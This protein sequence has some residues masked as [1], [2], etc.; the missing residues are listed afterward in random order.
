[1][2]WLENLKVGDSVIVKTCHTLGRVAT[3][4]K[5]R[6]LHIVVGKSKFRKCGGDMVGAY[7]HG[8]PY[9]AEA[10]QE[11]ICE[12]KGRRAAYQL[13]NYSLQ[14]FMKVPLADL[15]SFI[16]KVEEANK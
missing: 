8:K 15:E 13:A 6:K 2:N 16:K 1:M 12:L 10:T 9:L 7:G 3:V 11:A 4:E 5:V 14:D